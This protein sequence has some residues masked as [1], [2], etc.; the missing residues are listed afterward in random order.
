MEKEIFNFGRFRKYFAH[1]LLRCIKQVG[2]VTLITGLIPVILLFCAICMFTAT[3]VNDWTFDLEFTAGVAII[4]FTIYF[5]FMP[6]PCY[7]ELTEKR[8]GSN[9]LM[10]PA[11]HTEKYISM[12]INCLIIFPLGLAALYF[13]SDAICSMLFPSRYE[14]FAATEILFGNDESCFAT[15][16]FFLPAMVS[17]AGLCGSL[18]FRKGKAAKTFITCSVSFIVFVLILISIASSDIDIYTADGVRAWYIFQTFC[19]LCLLSYIYIKTKRI[20]L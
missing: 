11:S 12:I 4:V 9:F 3:G 14:G 6:I 1:D 8:K 7:G 13:G 5:L 10:L 15:W 19:T 20:Q 2:L 18:L 16:I 17:A